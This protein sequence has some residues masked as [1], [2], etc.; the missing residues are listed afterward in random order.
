MPIYNLNEMDSEVI[1]PKHSPSYGEL[2]TGETIE[3]GR[4]KW[5]KGMPAE[6]HSHP[7]EQIMYVVSGRL[8]VTMEGQTVDLLPGMAAHT[9]P[10]VKHEREAL[11]DTEVISCKNVIEGVGHARI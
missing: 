3:F 5:D 9:P 11:E 1:T 6:E 7:Q 8:R 4:I 10:N 2:I